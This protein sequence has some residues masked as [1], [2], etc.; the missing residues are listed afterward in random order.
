MAL[1][2]IDESLEPLINH[3]IHWDLTSYHRQRFYFPWIIISLDHC[4]PP[5]LARVGLFHQS[6][7]HPDVELT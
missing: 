5:G 1:F 4:N 6:K 3:L 7:G 2:V